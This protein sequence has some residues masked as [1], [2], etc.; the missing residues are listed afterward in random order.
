MAVQ[1]IVRDKDFAYK[2]ALEAYQVTYAQ[3]KSFIGET[4]IKNI[5]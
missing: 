5:E 3:Y 2:E 1:Q 4:T